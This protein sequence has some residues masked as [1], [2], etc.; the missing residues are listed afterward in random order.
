MEFLEL[1]YF[2]TVADSGSFSRAAVKLGM[3]EPS[4]SRQIGKLE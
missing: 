4:F 1:R 3:T 2:V